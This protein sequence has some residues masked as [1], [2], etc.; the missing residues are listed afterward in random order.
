MPM[1]DRRSD[2]GKKNK[3]LAVLADKIFYALGCGATTEE[4]Q[5]SFIKGHAAHL[6]CKMRDINVPS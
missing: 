6:K 3:A 1:I 5:E 4:I 2:E